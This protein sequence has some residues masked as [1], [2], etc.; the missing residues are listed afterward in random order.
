MPPPRGAPPEAAGRVLPVSLR[1]YSSDPHK[2][3]V[4]VHP[5][6]N[7]PEDE[8]DRRSLDERRPSFAKDIEPFRTQVSLQRLSHKPDRQMVETVNGDRIHADDDQRKEQHPPP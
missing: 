5:V 4:A 1:S 7:Q 6:Q 2:D 3:F 8:N